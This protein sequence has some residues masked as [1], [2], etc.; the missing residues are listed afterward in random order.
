VSSGNSAGP[1][2]HHRVAVIGAGFSGL[3]AAIRLRREG[4]EDFVVLERADEVGGTWQ[5]NTYPGCQCDVASHLYSFSFMPNPDWSRGYSKQPEIWEYLR[6]CAD[7]GG[8]RPHL[9]LGC[10]VIDASWD[11][12]ARRWRIETS[13][14]ALTADILIAGPGGLSEPSIP[15]FPGLESFDGPVFHSAAWDH[16]VDLRGKRVAVVGTG[17]SAI[18]IVPAI[19]PE[20]ARLDVF[21]RTPPWIVPHGDRPIGR[22]KRRLYR[23]FPPLQKLARAG[24]YMSREPLVVGLV[25]RPRLLRVVERLALRH[26]R[27]QVPDPDLRRRLRPSYRIGCKRILPSNEWYP[28]LLKENVE[29]VSEGIAEVRPEGIVDGAG[30][31][32]ELDAIVMATGFKV[33]DL[34]IA[35]RVRGRMGTLAETWRDGMRAYLGTTISGFPNLFMLVGPNTGLGHNSL[36][37]MIESQLNYVLDAL[38]LIEERGLASVDVRPEVQQAFND[39]LAQRLRGSVWNSGGCASWYLDSRGCNRTIWPRQTWSFRRM[40]RRFDPASYRLEPAGLAMEGETLPV[41]PPALV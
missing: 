41:H 39:D 8:V 37:Y 11:E 40:T 31:L 7:R 22:L 6:R 17:A 35:E 5:A 19:Q 4:I 33:M 29:V 10:E 27:R 36:V 38:R 16:D 14:G 21:Q 34:P 1:V 26:M 28:A 13:T 20:V 9:R 25:H 23:L 32:H 2:P 3:G 12:D 15:T 24:V 30:R 18:Q